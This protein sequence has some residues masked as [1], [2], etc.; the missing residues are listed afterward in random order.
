VRQLLAAGKRADDG[1][2]ER[3]RGRGR[4]LELECFPQSSAV[5]HPRAYFF[6]FLAAGFAAAFSAFLGVLFALAAFS[7]SAFLAA[8]VAAG[9]AAFAGLAFFSAFGFSTFAALGFVW[10]AAR[11]VEGVG[12]RVSSELKALRQLVGGGV[13]AHRLGGRLLRGGLGSC[14]L[15]G[16]H[17]TRQDNR[18][19]IYGGDF[20]SLRYVHLSTY[21]TYVCT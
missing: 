19:R 9:F 10:G 8:A 13:G 20:A 7:G 2:A 11:A 6:A 17:G 18:A 14:S 3:G 16:S 21:A 15:L 5:L 12:S 4:F 1:G